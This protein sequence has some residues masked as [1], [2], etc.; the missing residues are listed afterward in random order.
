LYSVQRID[1]LIIS[2]SGAGI[3]TCFE[4]MKYVASDAIMKPYLSRINTPFKVVGVLFVLSIISNFISQW[5]AYKGSS[6]ALEST[7]SDIYDWENKSDGEEQENK[8]NTT[9]T[10]EKTANIYNKITLKTN[11]ISAL[12]MIFGLLGL[13]VFILNL[14]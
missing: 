10:S 6:Y 13:I 3:Y 8:N 1:I 11:F 14:F 5:C 9:S 2:I 7:K 12:L 4:I